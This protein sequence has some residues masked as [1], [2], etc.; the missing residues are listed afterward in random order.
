MKKRR[1][2]HLEMRPQRTQEHEFPKG[3]EGLVFCKVCNA[4]YYKKSWHHNLRYYKNLRESLPVKFAV[5]PAC[6]MMQSGKFEG[7]ILITNAPARIRE[8]LEHLIHAFTHR[9]FQRDP[10]DRLIAIT[11]TKEGLEI[12][13]TE[14]QLAVKL[15]K[16]IK[17]VYKKVRMRVSFGHAKDKASNIV[18]EFL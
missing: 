5:C 9:A 13:A 11:Q 1:Q 17:D 12:T 15:A 16:K 8:N 10:M 3:K 14:N 4:V 6:V 2:Y 7:R 18:I